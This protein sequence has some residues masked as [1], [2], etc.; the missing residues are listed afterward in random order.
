MEHLKIK[1]L[2]P[3]KQANIKFGDLTLLLPKIS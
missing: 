3:I 1:S 2:G